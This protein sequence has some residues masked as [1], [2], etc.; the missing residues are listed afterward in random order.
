MTSRNSCSKGFLR[1]GLRRSLWAVV[2]SSVGFVMTLLLPALMTM[3]RGLENIREMQAQAHPNAAQIAETWD[4]ILDAAA[5]MLGGE[6][7]FAKCMV[8]VMAVVCGTAMF[9][10]LHDRR[11]VD[12]FHSLPVSRT[13]LFAHR[14][15]TGVV[16]TW[17]PFIIVYAV[18]IAAAFAMGY[19]DA[20]LR[21]G[22][23]GALVCHAV[24][25]L[26]LYAITVLVTIVCGNTIISL[27]LLC[28]AFFS[29][30][31]IRG[32]WMGL[33]ELFYT[34]FCS[35]GIMDTLLNNRLAP[36]IEY[37]MLNGTK[38]LQTTDAYSSSMRALEAT[39]KSAAGLLGAYLLAAVVIIALAA[40]LFRI[41][42]SERA[43]MALAF[44]P[45]KLPIKVFMCLTMGVAFAE[46]FW[47]VSTS[48][49]WFWVGLVAGT[50]I[51][52]CV[53]EIIYAFDFRAI[54]KKPLHLVIIL[55]VLAGG[56]LLMQADVT[57]YDDWLPDT[58][59]IAAADVTDL[60]DQGAKS[61]LSDSEN[62]AAIRR[63][64]EMGI[65]YNNGILNVEDQN[66]EWL[67]VVYY[68]NNGAVKRRAYTLPDSDE[69]YQLRIQIASS[70]E[71]RQK[72]WALFQMDESA[73]A[74][75]MAVVPQSADAEDVVLDDAAKAREIVSTLREET[76]SHAEPGTPVLRL[77]F[78]NADDSDYYYLG[79]VNV[80]D[81]DVKTLA[82]IEQYTGVRPQPMRAAQFSSAILSYRIAD[83]E[84]GGWIYQGVEVTDPADLAALMKNAVNVEAMQM[85]GSET[86][87]YGLLRYYDYRSVSFVRQGDRNDEQLTIAYPFGQW[88]Q[89]IYDKYQ[90]AAEKLAKT[91]TG[92]TATIATQDADI[93][94]SEAA[95]G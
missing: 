62:I 19:S 49:L 83:E 52:H 42:K 27:L 71:Y 91:E 35:D 76:L 81:K 63:I 37:F 46:L 53:V 73:P 22:I 1:E 17:L 94:V 84:N 28:W 26:L 38:Y 56:L 51:M 44:Q 6:N 95:L 75:T 9:A 4:Q 82:L 45:S 41:R 55:A 70:I 86:Y 18:T 32:L 43:G 66:C 93:T 77:D 87:S 30:T 74:L 25:F 13:K 50:V 16:C 90:A 5:A 11:K 8:I 7:A 59:K 89:E 58:D 15:V 2:L 48:R 61:A 79:A 12:F 60:Y 24:L 47:L 21:T 36:L 23:A 92:T 54:V 85:Y 68:M 64:A 33:K 72:K 88:P 39:Q 34:T 65:N 20:V 78:T 3:Q 69:L 57:G 10:Y 29:P 80:T 31:L 67:E 14:F 40:W